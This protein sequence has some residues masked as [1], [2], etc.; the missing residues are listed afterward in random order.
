MAV[1]PQFSFKTFNSTDV[2][3]LSLIKLYE[4]LT[5]GSLSKG[6]DMLSGINTVIFRLKLVLI[7]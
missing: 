2:W 7:G 5:A 3:V 1:A 6:S 4:F